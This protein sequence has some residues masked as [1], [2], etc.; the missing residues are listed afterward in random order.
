MTF[1]RIQRAIERHQ[2]FL[3]NDQT[4]FVWPIVAVIVVIIYVMTS[5][6]G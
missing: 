4:W 3:L 6:D 1:E 5:G 2:Q